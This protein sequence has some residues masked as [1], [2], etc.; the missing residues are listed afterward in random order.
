MASFIHKIGKAVANPSMAVDSIHLRYLLGIGNPRKLCNYLYKRSFNRK[1][2]W[3]NPE[4][5]NQWIA[6]LQFKTDTSLWV[7][8]AD[9]YRMHDYLK[10]KGF[11]DFLVPLLAKWESA[12]DIDFSNLPD[13]FVLKCNNGSGDVKIVSDKSKA[14]IEGLKEYF[15]QQLARRFGYNSAEPHYLKIKPL[16]IAEMLLDASRQPTVS[17]S[18]ID[19]KFW[20]FNG[21]VD[22]I[23]VCSDRT[24]EHYSIEMYDL[25]WNN[26]SETNILFDEHTGPSKTGINKPLSFETMKEV[27][28]KISKGFPQ[29]RL[30][31]YE[32]DGHPY[33]GELTMT[34]ACGRL[35]N[36]TQEVLN[37]MGNKCGAAVKELTASGQ[38]KLL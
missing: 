34:A 21:E 14:D 17:S 38:L 16:I 30:D 10:Q 8:L 20:C 1:I 26:I 36:Y 29:M 27:A 5:L 23:F 12:D 18:L 25:E 31:F 13:A 7:T 19:Y 33:I 9:K 24:K 4:D 11:G 37:E 3:K 6:W 22:R 15:R 28:S 2:N 35:P 32:I